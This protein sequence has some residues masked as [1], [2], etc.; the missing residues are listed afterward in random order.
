[1]FI[2]CT[3]SSRRTTDNKHISPR[4][5]TD[6]LE[7]RYPMQGRGHP[8]KVR[9]AW[10]R[11]VDVHTQ[12]THGLPGCRRDTWAERAMLFALVAARQKN[13]SGIA[14][15]GRSRWTPARRVFR[16]FATQPVAPTAQQC[17]NCGASHTFT[18][19]ATRRNLGRPETPQ[20]AAPDRPTTP[21]G[22]AS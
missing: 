6:L 9:G 11:W 5:L 12:G 21:R 1:M 13:S 4:R 3:T 15:H 8:P 17:L 16:L 18:A 10:G 22:F 7:H 19:A 2:S 20:D 14:L